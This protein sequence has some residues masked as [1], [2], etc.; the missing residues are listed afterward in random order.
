MKVAFKFARSS[1]IVDELY[2]ICGSIVDVNL[3]KVN[4]N[5]C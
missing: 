5:V 1:L 3:N 4:I 2:H